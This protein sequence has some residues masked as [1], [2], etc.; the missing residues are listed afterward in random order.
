[1]CVS[2]WPLQESKKPSERLP[3]SVPEPHFDKFVLY[4]IQLWIQAS[5][6]M[7]LWSECAE[8]HVWYLTFLFAIS[9]SCPASTMCLKVLQYIYGEKEPLSSE[10]LLP[11][12]RKPKRMNSLG[13]NIS[14]LQ[15]LSLHPACVCIWK[16]GWYGLL[17]TDIYFLVNQKV[18]DFCA[19]NI[20]SFV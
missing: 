18:H 4:H 3:L 19:Y 12:Q 17:K 7:S 10:Y 11:L 5:Y 6:V 2:S 1:M 16:F 15:C 13:M 20:Q 14:R 9:M 8:A